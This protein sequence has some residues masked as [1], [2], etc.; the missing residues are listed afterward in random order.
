MY[1]AILPNTLRFLLNLLHISEIWFSKFNSESIETPN[2]VSILLDL[3]DTPPI[4]VSIEDFELT[5]RW[6]FSGFGS[7]WFFFRPVKGYSEVDCSSEITVGM[8]LTYV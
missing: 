7:R 5:K 8:S 2:I 4:F 6:H 1:P 3:T